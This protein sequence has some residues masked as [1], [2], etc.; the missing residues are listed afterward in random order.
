[1]AVRLQAGSRKAAV[2]LLTDRRVSKVPKIVWWSADLRQPSPP[3][4]CCRPTATEH[5]HSMKAVDMD[6][7][8]IWWSWLPWGRYINGETA[9]MLH[10]TH[11]G[12]SSTTMTPRPWKIAVY[13]ENNTKR[14]NSLK[15]GEHK[16][17][18]ETAVELESFAQTAYR[19]FIS[20]QATGRLGASGTWCGRS[21]SERHLH[22]IQSGYQR[23]VAGQF[24]DDVMTASSTFMTD[25]TKNK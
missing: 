23:P 3:S 7:T 10:I 12:I 14:S 9:L 22:I 15:N 21:W 11:H 13:A 16:K 19:Q 2:R 24:P 8:S 6:R 25:L 5:G 17:L 1:M 18:S 20:P 4:P